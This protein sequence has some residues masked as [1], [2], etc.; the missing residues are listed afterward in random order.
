[1]HVCVCVCVCDDVGAGEVHFFFCC[2]DGSGSC[3]SLLLFL[4]GSQAAGAGR[5]VDD[6]LASKTF[7]A[8]QDLGNKQH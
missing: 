8:K 5:A 7:L 2:W 1:M 6:L 3:F 4:A